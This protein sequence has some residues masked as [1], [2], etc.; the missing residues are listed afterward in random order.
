MSPFRIPIINALSVA[1]LMLSVFCANT[2]AQ[3]TVNI[4]T[5]PIVGQTIDG[6]LAVNVFKGIPYAAPPVGDLR[7]REPQPVRAWNTPRDCTSFASRCPQPDVAGRPWLGEA[8]PMDEDCLYLNVWAPANIDKPLPVMVWIHGGGFT[9]GASSLR[10][11]DGQ[12][13]AQQGV[14]LVSINYRLGPFG[15]FGHP[16]LTV[17]SE[18]HFSGNYGLLDQIAALQWIQNNIANFGGDP[19]CVTIFGE[20]AGSVAVTCL[21]VSP[22][23]KGLFHRAI[24]QSGTG[25]SLHQHLDQ[26]TAHNTSLHETGMTIAKKLGIQD[27][28]ANALAALRDVSA[29]QLLKV[30]NP[31]LISQGLK[32]TKFGPVIDGYVLTGNPGALFAEGKQH[33]VPLMIGANAQDGIL[34]ASALPIKRV[35]GYEWIIKRRFGK[36]ATALLKLFPAQTNEDVRGALLDLTTVSAFVAPARRLAIGMQNVNTPAYLYHFSR[37]SPGAKRSGVG[38]AHGAEIPY[39]FNTFKNT[40]TYDTT[41][42]QLANVMRKYWVNFATNGNPNANGLTNWPAYTVDTDQHMN[43]GNTANV[44]K[45]LH[46]QACDLFDKIAA[47]T[48]H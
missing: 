36:D 29:E 32:G 9:I 46:K 19:N 28:N 15:F 39:L 30:S 40:T 37:V 27:E 3:V 20:S 7:W 48:D 5:G 33:A 14:V 44:S 31:Q 42:H 16:A 22:L 26:S 34:H 12:N 18:H 11:Y 23:S 45:N 10:F 2:Q 47:D 25:A 21:M 43:F 13:F 38:A 4:T 41:D 35:R 1:L 24:A 17:E 6:E 8:G